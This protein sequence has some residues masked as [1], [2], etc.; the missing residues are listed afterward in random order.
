MNAARDA[1]DHVATH[2]MQLRSDQDLRW[3]D[4]HFAPDV[5]AR[6][7]TF[8]VTRRCEFLAGR[9]CAQQAL[10]QIVSPPIPWIPAGHDRSPRWPDGIV[11]SITHT[12]DYVAAAVARSDRIGALGI[13]SESLL[14]ATVVREMAA[15]VAYPE[16]LALFR[17]AAPSLAEARVAVTLCFSMK[18]SL[19]KCL[20]PLT[21]RYV[22]FLSAQII[23]VH[24]ET[25]TLRL[26][27]CAAW[28]D[29]FPAAWA[30]DGGFRLDGSRVHTWVALPAS[31]RRMPS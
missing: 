16:E 14:P 31:S 5:D 21:Q 17:S 7:V 29:R 28:S 15:L 10:Q 24:A 11:G 3:L 13:D 12:T 25:G 6:G 23:A 1:M 27:L 2:A 4:D 20:Y 22:D 8:P 26:T 9:Y 30:C 19:F 18:E